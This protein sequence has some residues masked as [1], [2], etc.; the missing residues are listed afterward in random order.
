MTPHGQKGILRMVEIYFN[1]Q[2][3]EGVTGVNLV[4]ATNTAN[5]SNFDQNMFDQN[6]L[7]PVTGLDFQIGTFDQSTWKTNL[8]T[9]FH[10]LTDELL[11]CS[12]D[13]NIVGVCD[14]CGVRIFVPRIPG[15]FSFEK[16][17]SA[18]GRAMS[19]DED[20]EDGVGELVLEIEALQEA[21]DKDIRKYKRAMEVL[22]IARN[23]ARKQ[24]IKVAQPIE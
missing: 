22:Q 11:A 14:R 16:A 19:L 2:P 15:A 3:V 7:V 18:L 8:C 4:T 12:D 20:D 1:D 24:L 21:I 9:E 5:H 10:V 6:T 13:D 23:L 17:G